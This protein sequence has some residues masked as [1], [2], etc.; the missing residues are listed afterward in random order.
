MPLWGYAAIALVPILILA[1]FYPRL[2][3]LSRIELAIPAAS[4]TIVLAVVAMRRSAST[5][6]IRRGRA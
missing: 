3:R 1:T 4:W 5:R 6:R 2:D